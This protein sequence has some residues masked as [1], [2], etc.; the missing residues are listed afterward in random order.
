LADDRNPLAADAAEAAGLA[1][2]VAL[3]RPLAR[4]VQS[5]NKQI[6]LAALVAIRRFYSGVRTSPRGLAA[7]DRV[8]VDQDGSDLPSPPADLP[9]ETRAAIVSAVAALVADAYVDADVRQEAFTLARLLRGEHFGK[10]LADLADQVELEGTPLLG[11][12]QAEVRIEAEAR[13]R[14]VKVVSE[15]LSE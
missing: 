2:D 5:R 9:A 13:A 12:V 7:V 1:G 3:L 6:A 4:L 11:A 14:E 10:L 15:S 8:V